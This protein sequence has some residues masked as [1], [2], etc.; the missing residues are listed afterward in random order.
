MPLDYEE[1]TRIFDD[2]KYR[3]HR[4]EIKPDKTNYMYNGKVVIREMRKNSRVAYVWGKDIDQTSKQY[5]VDPRGW[6]WVHELPEQSEDSVRQ[7]IEEVISLREKL[8]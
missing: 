7:L 5:K 1:L 2:P 6:I 3:L 8:A 4:Y